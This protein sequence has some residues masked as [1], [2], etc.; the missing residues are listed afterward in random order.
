[1]PVAWSKFK[2]FWMAEEVPRWF[3]LSVVAVYMCGLGVVSYLGIQHA[4]KGPVSR[5]ERTL[6]YAAQALADHL[7]LVDGNDLVNAVPAGAL[8]R[9]LRKFAANVSVRSVRVVDADGQIQLTVTS[10]NESESARPRPML[11]KNSTFPS[12]SESAGSW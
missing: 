7:G 6:L 1:M 9:H 4:R 8:E 11:L 12:R 10:A 3:G 2:Q 5:L